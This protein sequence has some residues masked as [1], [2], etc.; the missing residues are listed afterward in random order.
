MAIHPHGQR[1]VDAGIHQIGDMLRLRVSSP[2]GGIAIRG[3]V[4]E[5]Q[6]AAL[7][8]YQDSGERERQLRALGY[9]EGPLR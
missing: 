2:E 7:S 5:R 9:L 8:P 4:I 3:F 6:G 1:L